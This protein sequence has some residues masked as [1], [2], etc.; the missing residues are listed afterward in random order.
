MSNLT[1]KGSEIQ[2]PVQ[3]PVSFHRKKD[4]SVTV[5]LLI[6]LDYFHMQIK[7]IKI[8]YNIHS[9]FTKTNQ[10]IYKKIKSLC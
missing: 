10:C 5:V 2:G 1:L 3:G 6:I 7:I 8:R 4:I 9:K